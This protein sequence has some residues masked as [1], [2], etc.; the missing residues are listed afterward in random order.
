MRMERG[1]PLLRISTE[2]N[3][4]VKQGDK[5]KVQGDRRNMKPLLLIVTLTLIDNPTP[6]QMNINHQ[7]PVC[8]ALYNTFYSH[9]KIT[10]YPKSKKTPQ[11][12]DKAQHSDTTQMLE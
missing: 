1:R 5:S 7:T 6:G 9:Q 2:G 4:K 12:E 10:W 11:V 3:T 8:T